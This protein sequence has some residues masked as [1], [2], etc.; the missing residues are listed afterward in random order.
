[1][2]HESCCQVFLNQSWL[3]TLF[4]W[5]NSIPFKTWYMWLRAVSEGSPL[6]WSSNS[7]N[8]V[9][10]TYSKTKYSFRLL[11]KTSIKLIRFSCL[12]LW[13]FD[14]RGLDFKIRYFTCNMLWI[15]KKNCNFVI[16][17]IL[18]NVHL[19]TRRYHSFIQTWA[20]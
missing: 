6:G 20:T 4:W 19:I 18:C 2:R 10:S 13:K 3:L 12:S 5:Q 7:S 15:C 16:K 1:M 11:R 17:N 14:V 9:W 8:T